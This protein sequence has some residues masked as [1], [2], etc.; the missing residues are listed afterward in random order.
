VVQPDTPQQ[1]WEAFLAALTTT[2]LG[3]HARLGLLAMPTTLE[4]DVVLEAAITTGA[5]ASYTPQQVAGLLE[6]QEENDQQQQQQQAL[7]TLHTRLLDHTMELAAL[8][9]LPCDSS[10]S[11]ADA[12]ELQ[13]ELA[14]LGAQ[15][16]SLTEHRDQ[17]PRRRGQIARLQQPMQAPSGAGA[18]TAGVEP[19][20][21]LAIQAR[22]QQKML[23]H[24]YG[25]LCDA[26]T[27]ELNAAVI[28]C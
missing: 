23:I 1:R 19:C 6:E 17:A 18:A 26:I 10:S 5:L 20:V 21:L 15:L 12:Q 27:L 7:E 22:L 9:R 14:D 25:L 11:Y 13:S 2:L 24:V 8:Q 4:E 28:C 3:L 16:D